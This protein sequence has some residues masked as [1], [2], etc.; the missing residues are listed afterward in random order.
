M[1][2]LEATV[3]ECEYCKHRYVREDSC[4]VC[5]AKC[6]NE[7]RERA[8]YARKS[9]GAQD[10]ALNLARTDDALRVLVTSGCN[11]AA[12]NRARDL[13]DEMDW[14]SGCSNWY[15]VTVSQMLKAATVPEAG[16]EAEAGEEREVR[17]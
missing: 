15:E 12:E 13:L 11:E 10:T 9:Q 8:E 3:Y 1:K 2:T 14:T 4:R 5:E 6:A 16:A 17:G 7:R